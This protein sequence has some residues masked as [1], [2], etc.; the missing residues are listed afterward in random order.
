MLDRI[1]QNQLYENAQNNQIN[2]KSAVLFEKFK[3]STDTLLDLMDVFVCLMH[4]YMVNLIRMFGM[5]L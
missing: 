2:T 3:L 1:H 4:Q 5:K